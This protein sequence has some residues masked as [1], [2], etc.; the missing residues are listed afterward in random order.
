MKKT[1]FNYYLLENNFKENISFQEK[2]NIFLNYFDELK[3]KNI[4]DLKSEKITM[5]IYIKIFVI[6]LRK[7]FIF[8]YLDIYVII[9]LTIFFMSCI[10]FKIGGFDDLYN[11]IIKNIICIYMNIKY[12]Y[13]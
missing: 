2:I 11:I 8:Y 4:I 12:L 7:I 6:H 3:I 1:N 5:K 9:V 13:L 10:F